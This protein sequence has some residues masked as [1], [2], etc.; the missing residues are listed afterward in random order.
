MVS[1]FFILMERASLMLMIV[2]LSFRF[3]ITKRILRTNPSL[4]RSI[5]IGIIGGALGILG[6]YLGI[7]Y[8]GA[9]VN[10]RDTGVIVASLIGGMPAGII[11]AIIAAAHRMLLGG[12]TAFP[13]FL[14][15]M[16]AGI[17][18]GIL[19]HI[20]GR[21][22][23]NV[24]F[25]TL[26][27][28]VIEM[29][30]LA[31]VLF[32]VQPHTLAVDISKTVMFSMVVTN[33]FSVAVLVAIFSETEKDFEN[34]TA[35]TTS[36]IFKIVENTIDIVKDGLAK[37]AEKLAE[38]I[39]NHTDF[40]AVAITDKNIVLA[41][42][43]EGKDHHLPNAP[44]LTKATREVLEK[45]KGRI[46]RRKSLIGCSK[47]ECP[48][49]SAVIAPIK[50]VDGS[51]IGSI[52]FYRTTEYAITTSDVELARG[53]SQIISMEV[54]LSKALK[55][56]QMMYE[57]RYRSLLSKFKPHFL[58]NALNVISYLVKNDPHKAREMIFELSE[59]LRYTVKQENTMIDV[60]KEMEFVKHYLQFMK[61][62]YDDEFEYEIS[63]EV[64][65]K[66]QIPS[67]ILQ[68]IIE[69]SIKH[70]K[71]PSKK[72]KISVRCGKKNDK[73]FLEVKD[74]GKGF[75]NSGRLKGVG[76]K[77]LKERLNN[78]FGSNAKI[79]IKTALN[80]GCET[81]IY[82][83]YVEKIEVTDVN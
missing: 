49:K 60:K 75:S 45:G 41:H 24:E 70:A 40:D 78:L 39:K 3:Q 81:R 31:F 9:I 42:V 26:Y 28:A 38:E 80:R 16:T 8:K 82:L 53:L 19:S 23:F 73:I 59:L 30:H 79:S 62:R 13:C 5:W 21:R 69:N 71:I 48:L 52:K 25:A 44:I 12:V 55:D 32:M 27:T 1:P 65:E 77:L 83:P 43:G 64:N 51:V 46:I 58:F 76:M 20:Y 72:L 63:N 57:V 34:I 29:V 17:V 36:A 61:Y 67:F 66:V 37:N 18:S 6:T 35:T 22:I 7:R 56:S 33:T 54:S 10:Y 74:N 2:Y 47:E 14:G 15:T 68:P 11:S 4:K 50:L